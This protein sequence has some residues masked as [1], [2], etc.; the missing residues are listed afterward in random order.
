MQR[1]RIL[2]FAT[3]LV[4]AGTTITAIAGQRDV[5]PVEIT[6]TYAQ[7]ALADARGSAD[8]RQYIG[9]YTTGYFGLCH[10]VDAAGQARGCTT[11]DP[12]QLAVMRSI[13]SDS[14]VGFRWNK[15]GTCDYVTIGNYSVY[16]SA[17]TSGY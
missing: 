8:S 13:S 5:I 2:S 4:L 7:G 3:A 1:T 14:T 11:R 17:A 15:E 16:R 12:E 6:A 9:C 10:A